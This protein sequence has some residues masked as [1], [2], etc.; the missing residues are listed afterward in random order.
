[1]LVVVMH[2]KHY[3]C[4]ASRSDHVKQHYACQWWACKAN[5]TAPYAVLL[6]LGCAASGGGYLTAS[7]SYPGF[8]LW[9]FQPPVVLLM[10]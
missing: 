5:T 9:S 10:I 8:L 7:F 3:T 1:M 6:R 2:N 4:C